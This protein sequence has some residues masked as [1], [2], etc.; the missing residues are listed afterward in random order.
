[1]E[2]YLTSVVLYGVSLHVS[3]NNHFFFTALVKSIRKM[4]AHARVQSTMFFRLLQKYA[5]QNVN[6]VMQCPVL[7]KSGINAR[8]KHF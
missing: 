7:K 5:L 3:L 8:Q 2:Q 1:M 4:F 6:D